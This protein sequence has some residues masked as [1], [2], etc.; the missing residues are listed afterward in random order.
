[1][2]EGTFGENEGTAESDRERR[3]EETVTAGIGEIV[4]TTGGGSQTVSVMR[5][6]PHTI[7]VRV[8]DSVEWTNLEAVTGHTVTFGIEP[9]DPNSPPSANVSDDFDGARHAFIGSAADNVHSGVLRNT[10]Q[11]RLGLAQ[12][13]LGVTRFRVTFTAPGTFRYICALHDDLGMVG[14]VIVE[15]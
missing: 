4:A 14:T 10:L 3:S 7:T 1:M 5:F 11:D 6:L 15:P 9:D 8:G 13:P 2:A 12:T